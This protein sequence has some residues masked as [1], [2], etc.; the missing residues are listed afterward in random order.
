MSA[1]GIDPGISGALAHYQN[2]R[3]VDVIDMPTFPMMINKKQ[4]DRLDMVALAEYFMLK[5]MM[6]VQIVMLEA[7]GG[8][9]RQSAS[10]GFVFGYTVG[11]LFAL[12]I[13][14][15]LPI[16]TVPPAVWKKVLQVPGKVDKHTKKM[17]KTYA[18]K[19]ITRADELIPD[20]RQMWRGDKGG[21]KVD[22]AE[23]ALLAMY[24]ERYQLRVPGNVQHPGLAE[25]K[26]IYEKAEV[27]A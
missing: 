7:V 12:C 10:A 13:Q 23:A 5:K 20:D 22:R 25:Y 19:I 27:G 3:M 6:G 16:T 17:D 9:P 8:R 11:A 21:L 2:G 1:I 18:S 24:G 15:R 14:V 4:R 26:L